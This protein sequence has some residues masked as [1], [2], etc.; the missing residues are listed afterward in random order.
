M[1]RALTAAT[2]AMLA[3]SQW[4]IGWSQ[5]P[6]ALPGRTTTTEPEAPAVS[7]IATAAVHRAREHPDRFP[8][9]AAERRG[10]R[11]PSSLQR[12]LAGHHQGP[13]QAHPAGHL[14]RRTP[15]RAARAH[16]GEPASSFCV[17]RALKAGPLA[18]HNGRIMEHLRSSQGLTRSIAEW[19]GWGS[20]PRPAD[21]ESPTGRR[22]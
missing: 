6:A 10:H 3:R 14:A 5:H 2:Q 8:Q 20:N 1:A 18:S 12:R 15:L 4:P 13:A 19:G 16:A 11:P 9:P 21:Y 22:G 17:R 7:T